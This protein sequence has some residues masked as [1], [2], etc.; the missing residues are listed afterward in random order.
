VWTGATTY[1]VGEDECAPD[2]G[3]GGAFTAFVSTI[4]T[5]ASAK[6]AEVAGFGGRDGSQWLRS[7]IRLVCILWQEFQ[8]PDTGVIV[9]LRALKKGLRQPSW[10]CEQSK[11]FSCHKRHDRAY[12]RFFRTRTETNSLGSCHLHTAD[13]LV[14]SVNF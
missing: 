6:R 4:K 7:R 1:T 8:L 5:R 9:A 14:A 12:P 13:N 10:T 11:Q 3:G 2:R